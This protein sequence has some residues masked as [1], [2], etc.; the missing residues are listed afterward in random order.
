MA[1]PV[2]IAQY[3]PGCTSRLPVYQYIRDCQ[4]LFARLVYDKIVPNLA[5][6]SLWVL[7]SGVAIIFLFDL[8][9]KLLRSYFIDV[10]GKKTDVLVSAKI[11]EQVMGIRLEARPVSAGAFARHMQ[12]F[13][14][15][16]EFF[17]SA[18][19]AALIDLPFALLFLAI[20][21]FIAGEL[22]FVPL[23]AVLV[24]M[25]H[26]AIIQRPMRRAI[27]EGAKLATQKHANLIESLQGLETIKTFN[28]QGRFQY[29]WE[30]AV[31]HMANW[32]IKS[33]RLADSVQNAAGF[34]QQFVS[35]AMIVFGVYLIA[36]GQLTMGGLIAATMLS[37]RAISPLV[38][39]AMLSTRYNQAKSAMSVINQIM[40]M[41]GEQDAGKH[42]LRPLALN[43]HLALDA[44]TFCYP[45]SE[46]PALRNVSL[47][48]Q[49]GE[50]VAV[51][52]RIG[53]GKTTLQ[54]ILTGLYRPSQGAVRFDHTDINQFHPADIRSQ[55]G[56]VPQEPSLFFGTIRDNITLGN[57][58][59][60]SELIIDAARR[61]GVLD[62]T[63]SDPAGLERDIGEGGQRLSG[64]QRQSIAIA[65]ALLGNPKILIMDEPTSSMDNRA[66]F[67]IKNQ[68]KNLPDSTTLVLITHKT[69]MLDV[70]DRLIVMEHGQV[71]ADGPKEKVLETLKQ[72]TVTSMHDRQPKSQ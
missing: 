33:R 5:F 47:E 58:N 40:E 31:A 27:D 32:G 6:E 34:L 70:V 62:F 53:S 11:F 21:W 54:R 57:P 69:A 42:Y 30:E 8:V 10:A 29:R 59:A 7:A 3:L 2:A 22:A 20:I 14:S 37:G 39:L 25:L 68:L 15:I 17:T 67:H 9:L 19:V 56:A 60:G 43:G 52:G 23:A 45:S 55:I 35:V 1:Y 24:L 65:R 12:E 44:V 71:V 13:E 36:A 50:K 38:Q 41:P 51:I 72:G 49:P 4:P 28:A 64:G 26:S 16:R 18:T 66:E 63:Q 48:I 46:T 61:S